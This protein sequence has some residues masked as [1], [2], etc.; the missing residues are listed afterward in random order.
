MDHTRGVEGSS[1]LSPTLENAGSTAFDEYL[2]K[3]DSKQFAVDQVRPANRALATQQ[4]T[5]PVTISV[6]WEVS[7]A[8][9]SIKAGN[10]PESVASPREAFAAAFRHGVR[11]LR[12]DQCLQPPLRRSSVVAA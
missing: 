11:R 6:S 7:K 10:A 4:E 2:S 5:L 9:E 8:E 12:D 1:P 3:P